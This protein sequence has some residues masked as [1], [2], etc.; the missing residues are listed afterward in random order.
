M[1][2]FL[3]AILFLLLFPTNV[4]ASNDLTVTCDG[5]GSCSK[6]S[7]LPI[8]D[9]NSLYPGQTVSS[10]VTV[11]NTSSFAG[12]FAFQVEDLSSSLLNPVIYLSISND[13]SGNDLVYGPV[14]LDLINGSYITLNNFNPGGIRDYYFHAKFDIDADN[15]YRDLNTD[16]DLTLGFDFVKTEKQ[17][18]N[19][20]SISEGGKSSTSNS[21]APK[22][23]NED[24][25]NAG[26]TNFRVVS[27]T[28]NSMTLAWDNLA[29]ATGYA[30]F[31]T[32]ADGESYSVLPSMI[33]DRVTQYTINNLA[34]A[35]YFVEI[36]GVGGNNQLCGSNRTSI[37]VSIYGPVVEGR[38]QTQEGDVLGK[39]Y[40]ENGQEISGVGEVAGQSTQNCEAVGNYLP[41]VLLA[42][43][44]IFIFLVYYLYRSKKTVRKQ[45]F[46]VL[47]TLLSIII[48][49]L[50]RQ[51]DCVE[52]FWWLIWLCKWYFVASI[53]ES[54]LLQLINYS[55]IENN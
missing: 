13:Q 1:K 17:S 23:E 26:P 21:E 20:S 42:I 54:L 5:G 51:C 43:Q 25:L 28:N 52:A 46:S 8:F 39:T 24:L 12:V 16:F 29:N 53:L 38:P 19:T 7:S 14:A 31:F 36:A 40:D 41:W 4:L 30:I 22:C 50:Y 35:N 44:S 33:P 32:R 34:A 3:L 49:Y 48:F 55:L 37:G 27:Q 47:I 15:A 45:L 18:L 11:N 10:K 2:K 6:S 9:D